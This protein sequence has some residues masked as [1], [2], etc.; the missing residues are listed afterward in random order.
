MKNEKLHTKKAMLKIIA[1]YWRALD[2]H[3][4]TEYGNHIGR[5]SNMD[6]VEL[7]ESMGR[8]DAY[9]DVLEEFGYF[10]K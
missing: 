10:K 6:L 7:H 4:N 2:Q 5:W 1:S 9:Q 3:I 8:R